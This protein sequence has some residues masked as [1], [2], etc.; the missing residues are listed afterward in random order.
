M[1]RRM[2]RAWLWLLLTLGGATV[3]QTAFPVTGATGVG[4]GCTRFT[5]NTLASSID[6][7]YVFDCQ[8][9]FLGGAVQPCGDPGTTAD[10]MFV[11][12]SVAAA[13]PNTTTP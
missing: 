7:C 13:D 8:S 6:F 3:F 2:K 9:G 12:C 4:G 1:N 5:T 10:D 11:D